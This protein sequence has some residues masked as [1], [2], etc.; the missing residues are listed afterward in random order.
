M[1]PA[2]D[3]TGATFPP[4]EIEKSFGGAKNQSRLNLGCLSEK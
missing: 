1:A 2:F 3:G 4:L